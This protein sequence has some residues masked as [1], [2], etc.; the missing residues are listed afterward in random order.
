[1]PPLERVISALL[2]LSLAGFSQHLEKVTLPRSPE[3]LAHGKKLFLGSCG[4]CHGPT[5]SGGTGADL[6]RVQLVRAPTDEDLVQVIRF[7]V[8]GTE[9]PGAYHLTLREATEVAAYVR[10]LAR[11]EL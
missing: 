1:M 7:G 8:P 6:S 10:S 4:Y 11:V 2:L 3:A 5:G 9:M